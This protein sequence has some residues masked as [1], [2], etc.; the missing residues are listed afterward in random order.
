MDRR[1]VIGLLLVSLCLLPGCCS[2]G[3]PGS[4]I[5]V[6]LEPLYN[7]THFYGR[8]ALQYP[9]SC[10]PCPYACGCGEYHYPGTLRDLPASA[11]PLEKRLPTPEDAPPE[12]APPEDGTLK[13]GPSEDGTLKDGPSETKDVD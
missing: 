8:C 7:F 4:D 13:D 12:D 2:T 10:P 9:Y 5:P 1:W 3:C 6:S 11:A